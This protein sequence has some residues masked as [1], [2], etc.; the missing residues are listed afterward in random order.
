MADRLEH[1]VGVKH[2][3]KEQERN[4]HRP[5]EFA[6]G[7]RDAEESWQRHREEP[8]NGVPFQEVF[9]VGVFHVV[10]C[11]FVL[12][13]FMGEAR[14]RLTSYYTTGDFRQSCSRE[15]RRCRLASVAVVK[16]GFGRAHARCITGGGFRARIFMRC[17]EVFSGRVAACAATRLA[18]YE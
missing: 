5:W 4:N 17:Y 10:C 6:R 12:V 15:R 7:E 14:E 1:V 13:W 9:L 8:E 11:W 2:R 16:C 3:A 18:L